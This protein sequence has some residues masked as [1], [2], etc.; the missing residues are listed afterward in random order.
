MNYNNSK[1][2]ND[3]SPKQSSI[4][5]GSYSFP[6]IIDEM[7]SRKV[8]GDPEDDYIIKRV[9]ADIV[10][11][12]PYS[13]DQDLIVYL[14]SEIDDYVEFETELYRFPFTNDEKEMEILL[15]IIKRKMI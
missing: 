4:M 6:M 10:E 3:I 11:H 14:E 5:V 9:I 7:D 13:D 12:E 2:I 8:F 15:K 1:I